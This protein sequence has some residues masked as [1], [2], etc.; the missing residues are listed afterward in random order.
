MYF[1][2]DVT[3]AGTVPTQL[4]PMLLMA[5]NLMP[6][7]LVPAIVAAIVAGINTL[8]SVGD[9]GCDVALLKKKMLEL[10]KPVMTTVSI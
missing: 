6:T 3:N 1:T 9:F 10:Q 8:N 2:C 5:A 4:V 7:N